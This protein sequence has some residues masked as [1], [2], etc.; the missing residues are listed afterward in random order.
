MEF[1]NRMSARRDIISTQ[2]QDNLFLSIINL[3]TT[4]E[5]ELYPF[6]LKRL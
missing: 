6:N 2:W 5:K 3:N 1:R 4:M